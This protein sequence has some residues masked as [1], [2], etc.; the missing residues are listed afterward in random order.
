[1][2]M[3]YQW[4]AKIFFGAIALFL[5]SL[6]GLMLYVMTQLNI[7]EVIMC[8]ANDGGIRIPA[9]LCKYYMLNYRLTEKDIEDLSEG[10]GLE[11]IIGG[12]NP[13]KYKIAKIFISNGLDINGVNHYGT[14]NLT[15]LH[16]AALGGNVED[17]KFLLSQGADF[18]IKHKDRGTA[19]DVAKKFHRANDKSRDR[20]EIIRL[21]TEAENLGT[22]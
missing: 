1:M 10:A 12:Y 18:R 16:A 22:R 11:F 14:L 3:T 6:F 5:T 21:L 2:G 19:L 15:P 17:L 20:S 4:M 7:D 13:D 9:N 8:S